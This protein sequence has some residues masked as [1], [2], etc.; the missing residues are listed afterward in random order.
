M[1]PLPALT[2][3]A[4]EACRRKNSASFSPCYFVVSDISVVGEDERTENKQTEKLSLNCHWMYIGFYMYVHNWLWMWWLMLCVKLARSQYK[5]FGQTLGWMLL[6]RFFFFLEKTTFKFVDFAE[7]TLHD[8]VASSNFEDH[9]RGRKKKRLISLEEKSILLP[10]CIQTQAATLTIPWVF[11]LSAYPE[12]FG[13]AS[14]P[15]PIP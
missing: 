15:Q 3:C 10:D 11:N 1:S 6:W 8:V 5:V 12:Y 14:F 13:L 2:F 4:S 7:I 9:K